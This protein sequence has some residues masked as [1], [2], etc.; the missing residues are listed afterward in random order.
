MSG[1]QTP[2]KAPEQNVVPVRVGD[3]VLYGFPAE[4]A[5]VTHVYGGDDVGLLVFRSHERVEQN[6]ES[7]CYIARGKYSEKPALEHWSV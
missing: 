6:G 1:Q 3:A 5:T 4:A 2:P 7:P